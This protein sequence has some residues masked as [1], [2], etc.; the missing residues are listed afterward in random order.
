MEAVT[1]TEG[2]LVELARLRERY[3]PLMLFQSGG[4]CDG[5]A[6]LC[7]RQGELL[8]GPGDLLLGEVAGV[9]FYVD[10][11]QYERWRRPAFQ[12]DVAAGEG[13]T[14]SLEGADGVRFVSRA[15]SREARS[16]EAS[17]PPAWSPSGR[18]APEQRA[19]GHLTSVPVGRT[20]SHRPPNSETFWQRIC[21]GARSPT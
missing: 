18:V 9:P 2:A 17:V 1:A 7:L 21:R 4:C 11:E 15:P 10:A 5:S 14:F 3:G 12:L 6:P 19:L 13:D 20:T 16:G 8:L